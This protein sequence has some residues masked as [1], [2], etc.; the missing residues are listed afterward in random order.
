MS[1]E[2]DLRPD[3]DGSPGPGS[4]AVSS[5]PKSRFI[6]QNMISQPT[7]HALAGKARPGFSSQHLE[8]RF[9]LKEVLSRDVAV[10]GI[11]K[12]DAGISLLRQP[13]PGPRRL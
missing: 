10:L 5:G 3:A 6:R 9:F 7:T 2:G 12:R 1:W 4:R 11:V 8:N 13:M